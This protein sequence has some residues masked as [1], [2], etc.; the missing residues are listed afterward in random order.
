MG[1]SKSND[2]YFQG[3]L[4]FP[5]SFYLFLLFSFLFGKI[6][7]FR[8]FFW[9][10]NWNNFSS[11]ICPVRGKFCG[12]D[13]RVSARSRGERA[14]PLRA[15]CDVKISLLES[16][17]FTFLPF[18]FSPFSFLSFPLFR[19]KERIKTLK[20]WEI[21][22]ETLEN[23]RFFRI[24]LKPFF[25]ENFENFLKIFRKPLN[26]FEIFFENFEHFRT[27]AEFRLCRN[28]ALRSAVRPIVRPTSVRVLQNE[29]RSCRGMPVGW[30]AQPSIASEASDGWAGSAYRHPRGAHSRALYPSEHG[31][32]RHRV[33]GGTSSLIWSKPL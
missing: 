10:K 15:E 28:S 22:K 8:I 4:L 14:W 9:T 26:L 18:L 11:K 17:I 31:A 12:A 33:Q 19:N 24:R 25:R 6:F 27:L 21:M 5:F 30:S 23:F 2:P 7:I 13:V 3:F 20:S 32:Q 16:E 1:R 29:D